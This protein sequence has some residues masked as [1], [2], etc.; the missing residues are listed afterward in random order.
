MPLPFGFIERRDEDLDENYDLP[1]GNLPFDDFDLPRNLYKPS[2]LLNAIL[3]LVPSYIDSALERYADTINFEEFNY[4]YKLQELGSIFDDGGFFDSDCSL[5]KD[6]EVKE[7]LILSDRKA[8]EACPIHPAVNAI[9]LCNSGKDANLYAKYKISLSCMTKEDF[10]TF[11][12]LSLRPS[13]NPSRLQRSSTKDKSNIS[14]PEKETML[15]T[16]LTGKDLILIEAEESGQQND[17][18]IEDEDE[19]KQTVV[20]KDN[21]GDEAKVVSYESA[22]SVEKSST[23]TSNHTVKDQMRFLLHNMLKG[24]SLSPSEKPYNTMQTLN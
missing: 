10:S 6:V 2:S 19:F 23:V 20:D 3:R 17:G 4:S 5:L 18:E 16:T 15:N 24:V 12:G 13:Q 9:S 14:S 8:W 11:K 21:L 7:H 22:V 1:F